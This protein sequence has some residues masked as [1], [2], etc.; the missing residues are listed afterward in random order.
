MNFCIKK[1]KPKFN[2]N[3]SIVIKNTFLTDSNN[4]TFYYCTR[5]ENRT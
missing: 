2:I 5:Y 1:T 4:C 3:D